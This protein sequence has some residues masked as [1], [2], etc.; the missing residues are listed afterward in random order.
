MLPS[1]P[2]ARKGPPGRVHAGLGSLGDAQHPPWVMG[3]VLHLRGW[4]RGDPMGQQGL[5]GPVLVPKGLLEPP[6]RGVNPELGCA[7]HGAIS[8]PCAQAGF[9]RLDGLPTPCFNALSYGSVKG[10]QAALR[11]NDSL[12]TVPTDSRALWD[13][14]WKTLPLGVLWSQALQVECAN[15][16]L[17]PLVCRGSGI[18]S[19]HGLR[20]IVAIG[21]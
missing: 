8:P 21:L 14:K 20:D 2:K 10:I 17:L 12:V 19:L 7:S 13:A 16:D 18:C 15:S 9:P 11:S 1:A 4:W 5:P 3:S 6:G